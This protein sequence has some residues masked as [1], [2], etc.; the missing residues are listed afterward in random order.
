MIAVTLD[1]I[2]VAYAQAT[3]F[4]DLSWAVHD[5]RVVG[6]V[7]PNGCGKSTVLKAIVGE[8][9][10]T[11][12]TISTRAGLT[13]G[14]LP[15]EVE[16]PEDATVYETVRRGAVALFEVERDLA[17]VEAR[18]IDPA[19]YEDEDALTAVLHEQEMLLE[20]YDRLGGPSVES[21]IRSILSGLGFRTSDF[22]RPV[23]ILSGGQKKMV[24]LAAQAV[25]QPD[26]LLLD[27]PDNHLDLTGKMYLERFL[28]EYNGGV[29][30]VSHDRYLL[31]LV[32]DEIVELEGGILTRFP[33]NYSEYAVEKEH[34]RALHEKHFA[35]QQKEIHRLE[36]SAK[37][38]L[39]WGAVFDNE[40]F[41]R[42]GQAILKRIDRMDQIDHPHQQREMKLS[43][44]GWRGSTKVL[45][46]VGLS[47]AYPVEGESSE[48]QVVLDELDLLI[49]HGERVGLVG[50]NG[51]GK[52]V[53][54]R[55]IRE[56]EEPTSGEVIR[57][58]SV[59]TGYYAQEHETLD[60]NRSLIDN[61]RY[62]AG[63]SD[64]RAMQVLLRFALTYDQARRPAS[65]LSGGERSR[66]QLALIVLSGANFLM[67]DEPT[68]NLDIRSA[69]TLEDTLEELEGTVLVISHDRYF[70]DRVVDRI[71]ELKDGK[72][73]NY[74]GGYSEYAARVG[75]HPANDGE[76]SE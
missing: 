45:E 2:R 33:G 38:L 69:E 11:E 5:D 14:Y 28:R 35:D 51:S 72:L 46:A 31:D 29:V 73:I 59:V 44:S 12:G 64:T 41:I 6:L 42:R 75:L 32:V 7:G 20:E 40:K 67:L 1:R 60:L 57:G 22:D 39:T 25:N 27:E 34:Q 8:V 4:A 49:R 21:R 52:S 50:A 71:V 56:Q 16:F 24:A 58:P 61:L 10:A 66:L 23:N 54:F 74:S 48:T 26:L 17:I 62:G 15:Q 36:Q 19:V 3:V 76:E 65:D 18:L 30:L 43:I 47:K 63:V 68:N 53:L 55:L 70:L 37:R 9:R 13:I